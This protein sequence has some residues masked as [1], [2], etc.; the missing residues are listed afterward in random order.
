MRK[1]VVE[2]NAGVIVVQIMLWL[3]TG[4]YLVGSKEQLKVL[5]QRQQVHDSC[6]EMLIPQWLWW[7]GVLREREQF[8]N[9]YKN[10]SKHFTKEKL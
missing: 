9:W 8:N 4:L 10:K 2:G 3:K 1:V 5:E 6:L 7:V